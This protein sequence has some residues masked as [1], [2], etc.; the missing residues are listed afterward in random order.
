MSQINVCR[1]HSQ[2][3]A[4]VAIDVTSTAVLNG[5]SQETDVD[6]GSETV[7]VCYVHL[8]CLAC[9]S[10]SRYCRQCVWTAGLQRRVPHNDRHC[11]NYRHVVCD[12]YLCTISFGLW[13][14][15]YRFITIIYGRQKIRRFGCE[16]RIRNNTNNSHI[17]VNDK[18]DV[19]VLQM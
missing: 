2:T 11:V 1:L 16:L 10:I 3:S 19:N 13:A 9:L 7:H 4:C 18:P 6:R 8:T 5:Y 15:R 12:V 14:Q 17:R